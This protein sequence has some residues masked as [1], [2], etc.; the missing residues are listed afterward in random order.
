[1]PTGRRRARILALQT[2]FEVD[3]VDHPPEET[4]T[5]LLAQ[6]SRRATL[7]GDLR[8]AARRRDAPSRLE[9]HA[10]DP[11]HHVAHLS[12][13]GLGERERVYVATWLADRL[14]DIERHA[15]KPRRMIVTEVTV[16]GAGDESALTIN[17]VP[18]VSLRVV[19][20]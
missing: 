4:L 10:D 8:P 9:S 18:F 12:L 13:C 7:V 16:A 5:R 2:L 1:M 14:R 6:T 15:R 20:V 17:V 3:T 19:H 11:D